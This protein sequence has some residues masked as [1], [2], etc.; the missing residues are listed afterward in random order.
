MPRGTWLRPLIINYHAFGVTMASIP[1][2]GTRAFISR[3][4]E[5]Y[6]WT[7]HL[8]SHGA[9]LWSLEKHLP[10]VAPM[11][12]HHGEV[13]WTS[14]YKFH[15]LS[16]GGEGSFLTT[17]Y[18]SPKFPFKTHLEWG[19]NIQNAHRPVNVA[20][21]QSQSPQVRN[22]DVWRMGLAF[23]DIFKFAGSLPTPSLKTDSAM[24]GLLTKCES[25][26]DR[27]AQKG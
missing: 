23:L 26:G 1:R 5:C 10:D 4:V 9:F 18:K 11:I 19:L 17:D 25:C 13:A 16:L 24:R 8:Y 22:Q 21:S 27:L 14:V 6:N 7:A 3:G 2:G 12:F 15:D 20:R